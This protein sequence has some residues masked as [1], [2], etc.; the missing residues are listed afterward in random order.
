MARLRLL[1]L[2]AA[3]G[4]LIVLVGCGG[5][6]SSSSAGPCNGTVAVSGLGTPALTIDAT[7]KL[8]F[9]P[10]SAT[11][12]VGDVVEFKNIGVVPHDITFQDA[13]DGCLTDASFAAGATWE[14]RFTVAGIYNYLCVLHEP[15]M[16]GVITVS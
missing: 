14:V 12:K 16:K 2:A 7:D 8:L 15:N 13:D 3:T 10:A 1:T 9:V 11:V 6:P 4:A 5:S